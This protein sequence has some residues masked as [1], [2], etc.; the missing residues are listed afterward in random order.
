MNKINNNKIILSLKVLSL[1]AFC[2][3]LIPAKVFATPGYVDNPTPYISSITPNSINNLGSNMVI[4]ITGNG[5]IPSSIVRINGSDRTATFI[6]STHIL[7]RINSNDIS[8]TDGFY[9]N[10]FNGFPG[11]GYSNAEFFTVNKNNSTTITSTTTNTENNINNNN[12]YSNTNQTQNT[13]TK[14]SNFNNLAS[15]AIFG[16]NSFF[17]SGLIQWILF[18]IIILLIIILA[19]RIFGAHAKYNEAPMKSP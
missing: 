16:S 13:T 11:G 8:D 4:T 17:P 6:D 3:L 10:V 19:R 1:L 7:V 18:A 9:I 12:T 2:L 14:N 5:F 15:T